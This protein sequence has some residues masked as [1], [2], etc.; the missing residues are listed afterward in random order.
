MKRSTGTLSTTILAGLA[1]LLVQ[2]C[3]AP[4]PTPTEPP[5][6]KAAI[7]PWG[8]DLTALDKT[9]KPGDDF[10]RY[11]G[12]TW[13]KNATIRRTSRCGVR[14]PSLRRRRTRTSG[15]SWSN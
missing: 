4:P 11:A 3:S 1:I 9:I 14:C 12:G 13:M 15:H 5:R 2:G 7:A 10:Y 6:G 8:F